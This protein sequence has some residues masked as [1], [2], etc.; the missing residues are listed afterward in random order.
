M[1]P[2]TDR[3]T[4]A[5]IARIKFF[6]NEVYAHVTTTQVDS[7]K[8]ENLWQKISK[9]L[10]D[11]NIPQSEIDVLK[12]GHLSPKEELY[13]EQLN[14]WKLR[15]DECKD[16]LDKIGSNVQELKQ[17]AEETQRDVKE[18][19]QD[20]KETQHDVKETQRDVK[21]TQHDVKETQHDVKEPT[22]M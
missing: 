20:V 19:H 22:K 21:E 2:D 8:F 5:N 12:N 13:V 6:R 10:V 4:G 3:S 9:T 11:L 18:I 17:V 1:P 14:D 16:I 7:V 15:E